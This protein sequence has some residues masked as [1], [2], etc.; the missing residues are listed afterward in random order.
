MGDKLGWVRREAQECG[1]KKL[2]VGDL[3]WNGEGWEINKGYPVGHVSLDDEL[4]ELE[5]YRQ[6]IKD[7]LRP[8][9]PCKVGDTLYG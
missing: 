2:G 8:L 4:A 1:D 9:L 5:T 3:R 6:Q 7:G